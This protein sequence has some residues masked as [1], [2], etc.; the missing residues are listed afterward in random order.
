M[1]KKAE[2]S[3][4]EGLVI[5]MIV[6]EEYCEPDEWTFYR[7]DTDKGGVVIR[8]HGNSN[9]YYSTSVDFEKVDTVQ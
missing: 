7:L 9:G 6:R 1:N 3:D 2:F 5:S 8:W 4:L